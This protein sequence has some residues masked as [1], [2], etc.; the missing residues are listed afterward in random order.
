MGKSSSGEQYYCDNDGSAFCQ[1]KKCNKRKQQCMELR[2]LS[3]K[4]AND[5]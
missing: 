1:E 5:L 2:L 4:A 3:I